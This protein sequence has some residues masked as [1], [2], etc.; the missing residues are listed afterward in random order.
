MSSDSDCEVLY[1]AMSVASDPVPPAVPTPP[2]DGGSTPPPGTAAAPA[3]VTPADHG[4]LDETTL[5]KVPTRKRKKKAPPVPGGRDALE[6]PVEQVPPAA[7]ADEAG[8]SLTFALHVAAL[9]SLALLSRNAAEF[10]NIFNFVTDTNLDAACQ[11]VGA[12]RVTVNMTLNDG[13]DTVEVFSV[14][15]PAVSP[16]PPADHDV[17]DP[18]GSGLWSTVGAHHYLECRQGGNLW[19]SARDQ[20]PSSTTTH[21]LLNAFEGLTETDDD[22]LEAE[23]PVRLQGLLESCL[24]IARSQK[25]S[26]NMERNCKAGH[27]FEE[28]GMLVCA[29][30]SA[31][32]CVRV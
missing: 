15:P 3:P 23:V 21:H 29:C 32:V 26:R 31:C 20:Q 10:M 13:K 2:A 17:V 6:P 1:R 16:A 9:V 25:K 28:A 18:D 11:L 7:A 5:K 22:G 19:K 24:G 12:E 30:A 14:G 8:G 27:N 4:L